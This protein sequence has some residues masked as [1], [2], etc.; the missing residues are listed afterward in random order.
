MNKGPVVHNHVNKLQ[1][2]V[3][4]FLFELRYNI[5]ESH[6]QP[7]SCTLLLLR[8]TQEASPLG[9]VKDVEDYVEDTNAVVQDKKGYADKTQNYVIEA[10]TSHQSLYHL[11]KIQGSSHTSL[12][13]P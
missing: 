8:V 9:Y 4:A 12:E 10:P 11:E 13:A 1:Q 3:H 2:E 7:K 5:D 6:I